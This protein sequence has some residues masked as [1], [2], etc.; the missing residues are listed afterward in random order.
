MMPPKP[1]PSS[2]RYDKPSATSRCAKHT[3]VLLR[4]VGIDCSTG[5]QEQQCQT[6]A[7]LLQCNESRIQGNFEITMRMSKD[8]AVTPV[9]SS[10]QAEQV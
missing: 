10:F 9:E 4:G 2:S 5:L 1:S 3:A 8:V 7:I 6:C